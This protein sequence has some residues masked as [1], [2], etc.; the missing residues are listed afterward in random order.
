MKQRPDVLVVLPEGYRLIEIVPAVKAAEPPRRYSFLIEEARAVPDT[1]REIAAYWGRVRVVEQRINGENDALAIRWHR[2]LADI[3]DYI[4]EQFGVYR[5]NIEHEGYAV[6]AN[7]VLW[8]EEA[9]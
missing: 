8:H 2:L 7:A 3:D 5:V 1:F 4:L 6:N 9:Q